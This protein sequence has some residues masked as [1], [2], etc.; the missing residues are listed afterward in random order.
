MMITSFPAQQE[1]HFVSKQSGV[2]KKRVLALS[3]TVGVQDITD[4]ER[5][6]FMGDNRNVQKTL[7]IRQELIDMDKQKPQTRAVRKSFFGWQEENH[8]P[9][10]SSQDRALSSPFNLTL[11]ETGWRQRPDALNQAV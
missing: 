3:D 9:E 10:P 7:G 11:E 2:K 5:W 4:T 8:V 6:N 1:R